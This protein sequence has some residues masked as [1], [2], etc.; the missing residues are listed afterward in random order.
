MKTKEAL[1]EHRWHVHFV[2]ITGP[3][4]WF[5]SGIWRSSPNAP[6]FPWDSASCARMG[7]SSTLSSTNLW[8]SCSNR[9]NI[10]HRNDWPFCFL[11]V[12]FERFPVPSS[13]SKLFK[14][15]VVLNQDKTVPQKSKRTYHPCQA[16]RV[17]STAC[18]LKQR[19]HPIPFHYEHGSNFRRGD[20]KWTAMPRPEHFSVSAVGLFNL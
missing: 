18:N 15:Y 3:I 4:S 6:L 20:N 17:W 9:G 1:S 7:L 10:S 5:S 11:A 8:I 2:V 12:F 19:I 13:V 16:W 14:C